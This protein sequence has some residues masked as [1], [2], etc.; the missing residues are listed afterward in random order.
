MFSLSTKRRCERPLRGE[1]RRRHRRGC[2]SKNPCT[3]HFRGVV[4]GY[5]YYNPSTG[6]WISR[7]PYFSD[8]AFSLQ[9]VG[10][11]EQ[12]DARG[13]S[14]ASN[15]YA[16]CG[17]EPTTRWDYLGLL[18][19]TGGTPTRG[20]LEHHSY[21][22]FTVKCPL[23][24]QFVFDSVDYSGAVPA[25]EALFGKQNV[26]SVAGPIPPAS[27]LGGFRGYN[28]AGQPNCYGNP[29]KPQVYM[30]TR[31]ASYSFAP[32][33]G[34]AAASAYAAGTVINYHC[35]PCAPGYIPGPGNP[36]LPAY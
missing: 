17:N 9:D 27:G 34:G 36:V 1:A 20:I 26:D 5:R 28:P 13:L 11:E 10:V 18:V 6:R 32:K 21:L 16:F 29:T 3:R 2:E 22:E 31:Y 8:S 24:S 23:C 33:K 4:S 30:R 35:A 7:D 14:D 15:V 25:L 12:D 19:A